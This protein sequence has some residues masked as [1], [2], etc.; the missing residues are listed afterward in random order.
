MQKLIN[1][2]KRRNV[3]RVAVL[4]AVSGWLLLQ[5]ADV[6]VGLLNLPEWSLRLV[7]MLL[8]VG[9]PLVVI[10]SFVFEITP[11]GIKRES[12]IDRDAPRASMA[13][14]K[15]NYVIIGVLAVSLAYFV[16]QSEFKPTPRSAQVGSESNS[17]ADN[18]EQAAASNEL[19]S[20]AV[21]PFVDM[22]PN[23]DQEYFADG[24]SEELLNLL[25]RL[26]GLRVAARTSSFAYK[27]ANLD[28]P[29]IGTQLKVATI[30]EGSVRRAGN[31]V[32]VTAQLIKVA[33]G[34]HLWSD[35]YD[36]DVDDIFAVQD[37]IAMAVV[38]A[39]KPTLLAEMTSETDNRNP[40]NV[41][42]YDLYLLGRHEFHK[43]SAD[44]LAKAVGYFER[45]IALDP[46][47]A[48]AYSGLADSWTLMDDYA[49][50]TPQDAALKAKVY[51]DKVL[52][53]APGLAEAQASAGLYYLQT[54]QY[55]TARTHLEKAV[56]LNPGYSM[57]FSWLANTYA[58]LQLYRKQRDALES[59]FVLDPFHPVIRGNLAG[60]R[61]ATGQA[62]QARSLLREG[63]EREPENTRFM[64]PLADILMGSG[65][66]AE[67][68]QW[69][70]RA[71]DV[72]DR[73]Q[74]NLQMMAKV[75]EALE[76]GAKADAWHARRAELDP[77]ND[78]LRKDLWVSM[79]RS[80]NLAK[81]EAEIRDRLGEARTKDPEGLLPDTRSMFM[82]NGLVRNIR[83]DFSG[84]LEFFA[85]SGLAA[86]PQSVAM[87]GSFFIFD[88]AYAADNAGDKKLAGELLSAVEKHLE[89]K[90]ANGFNNAGMSMELAELYAAQGRQEDSIE[91]LTDAVDRGYVSWTEFDLGLRRMRHYLGSDARFQAQLDRIESNVAR[92]RELV[93]EL[94]K[95]YLKVST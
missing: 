33:D 79:Y 69:A 24:I 6:L 27:G 85:Q 21:L 45:A 73:D 76:E 43:R 84:A 89:Q 30:L 34:Y 19:D 64:R 90:R 35:T 5:F 57:G 25:S 36:R 53:I 61:Y 86:T 26:D 75:Y 42:A 72:D 60:I 10:F 46:A 2:L 8:I 78:D 28:I 13:G 18:S 87:F 3:F 47:F 65:Q 55:E 70:R 63:L 38:E 50:M 44:S 1:E 7:L 82:V 32:R 74:L 52:Q 62:E 16:V 20:I 77:D 56:Q 91:M 17:L 88:Y 66:L 15:L 83:E 31:K 71:V 23:K 41:Q 95:Q 51:V 80:G 54:A 49:G 39:L 94:E 12:E 92:Q 93:R 58:N 37:E 48:L 11:E 29:S 81:V 14:Q 4:Y 68:W 9:F 22:S 40:N 59:A 67:A